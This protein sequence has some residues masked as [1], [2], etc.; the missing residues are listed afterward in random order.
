[1]YIHVPGLSKSSDIILFVMHSFF[2]CTDIILFLLCPHS[3]IILNKRR[4]HSFVVMLSFFFSLDIILFKPCRCYALILM[5]NCYHSSD[6]I[7]IQRYHSK[8]AIS[9]FSTWSLLR[10]HSSLLFQ[11]LV[12]VTISFFLADIIL[13][14]CCYHSFVVMISFFKNML[15]FFVVMLSFFSTFSVSRRCYDIILQVNYDLVILHNQLPQHF[16]FSVE[17]LLQQRTET[18]RS[19]VAKQDRKYIEIKV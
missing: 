14:L 7:L 3:D 17:A 11:L 5:Q 9:F 18:S 6:I 12:V 8:E 2:Y 1:M 19:L 10:Y 4:Y 15:S 13:F 16:Q